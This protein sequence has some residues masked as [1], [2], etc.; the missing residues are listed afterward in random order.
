MRRVVM[1]MAAVLFVGAVGTAQ[2]QT[3]R[4]AADLSGANETPNC[5]DRRVSQ[6]PP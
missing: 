4:L 3:I 2:A 5:P 6:P 1:M